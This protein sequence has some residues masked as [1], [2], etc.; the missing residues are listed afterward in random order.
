MP[1]RKARKGTTVY[2]VKGVIKGI[3]YVEKF[4]SAFSRHQAQVQA[5]EYFKKEYNLKSLFWLE[6][7]IKEVRLPT[8]IV[9]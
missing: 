7:D 8:T 6:I 4:T 3:G 5:T 1:K 9:P 2:L